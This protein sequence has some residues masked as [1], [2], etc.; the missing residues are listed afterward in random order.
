[1]S[2]MYRIANFDKNK[3]HSRYN[4]SRFGKSNNSYRCGQC[5]NCRIQSS[6]ELSWF[7]NL[8]L[9]SCYK[10]GLSSSFC[11]IT[12]SDSFLPLVRCGNEIT[13]TLRQDDLSKF[14]KRSR[15]W[16]KRKKI[17]IPLRMV[18][19]GEYGDKLGRSH[20]HF[21]LFGMPPS[22]ADSMISSNWS[23]GLIDV[24]IL[25]SGGVNYVCKYITKAPRGKLAESLFDSKGLER[26][27]LVH[28]Q[29][30]GSDWILEHLQELYDNNFCYLDSGKLVPVPSYLRKK[31][32]STSEFD[33]ITF[34]RKLKTEAT[35][36]GFDSVDDYQNIKSYNTEK[37][38]I[39]YAR[40]Q[41]IPVESQSDYSSAI[42]LNTIKSDS[43]LIKSFALEA[44]DPIPF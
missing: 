36:H 17:D 6:M 11:T 20:Y 43:D 27:F 26:P 10:K 12:Y 9:Q 5:M 1:M 30:L 34:N 14:F 21:I 25:T 31:L 2:C 15:Q 41:G 35:I 39:D 32:D 44:L 22:L 3:F 42:V 23:Y 19:C 16:L 4:L 18:S 13:C 40:S 7:S 37:M 38:L 24:G 33:R 29:N 8:E 28:S